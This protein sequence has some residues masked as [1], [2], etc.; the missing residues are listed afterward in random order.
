MA[1]HRTPKS[2]FWGRRTVRFVALLAA[3]LAVFGTVAGVAIA[4]WTSTGSA[5]ASATTGTLNPPTA[6]TGVQTAGTGSVTVSW[7][8]PTGGTT[9]SGYYVTRKDSANN[10]VAAC[11]T[12]AGSTTSST[13]CSDTSV[14]LGSYTYTVVA[15]F[16]SWTA[17]S[18]ASATVTVAKAA[19]SITFTSSAP[20]NAVVNGPVYTVTATGGGS[21]NAV[22]FSSATTG[23]CTVSGA[24]VSFAHAGTCT[25]NADQAGS[26]YYSPA[27]TAQQTFAVGKASQVISF[28]SSAPTNAVVAGAT[29]TVT[30]LGGASGNPV[31]FSIDGVSTSVCSIS[32]STVSYQHVGSCVVDANQA[33]NA[34]YLAAPQVQQSIAVGKGSQAVNFTSTAPS[35]AQVGGSY[36]PTATSTAGLA[37]AITLDASS[38]GCSLSSGTVS[39]TGVGTCKIDANQPGNADYLAAAQVQQSFA[40]TKQNQTISF[41]S[42]APATAKVGGATYTAVATATSGLTVSFGT[43]TP[44]VCTSSGTNGATISFL[45]VGTCTVTA[46]QAGNGTYNAA[47]Q[48]T[49]SFTVAKGD[50]TISFTSTASASAKNGGAT[51]TATATATSGL[52]VIFGTSTP[53]VCTSSGANG[54]TITFVAAGN[55]TVTANQAG[56]TTYNAAPQ[57]TQ[58]F[59]VAKGD[60]T[61]TFT[62]TAPASTTVG[63]PTYTPTATSNSGLAVAITLDATSSGCTLSSGVVSFTAVGT[64]KIDANQSGDTNW[65]A[66]TQQ[67]QSITVGKGSQTISFTST[68][69]A[70]ATVGGATYTA[71]A[72]ATSGLTVSF[73]SATTSVC[74]SGG[75]NGAVFTFVAAGTCTVNANQAGNTNYNAAPQVQQSF[76]VVSVTITTVSPSILAHNGAVTNVTVSGTGFQSGIAV[77]LSDTTFVVQSVT[78][79]N[80]TQITVAIKNNYTNNGGHPSSL[81]VTNPDAT[82]ATKSNAI[83]N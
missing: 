52:T 36:T 69:P 37:V 12:S 10:V 61:I 70:N 39:F 82:T 81:T 11:G 22:T 73:T 43:S 15:V 60:Q 79:V 25:I 30:A 18:A 44:S 32:G 57:V 19:Q 55:C 45:A 34:D 42:T 50:Q 49:Q 27:T 17:T 23:V 74:T 83:T 75:T 48:V 62:S 64:C 78:F 31:V 40:I 6:V 20:A 66:A 4:Y 59:T 5:T 58:S 9:P 38:S 13:S 41:S 24:T 77:S 33:G 53:A 54:A 1:A 80:S 72:T 16:R 8:A 35:S 47:P 63:G 26:T 3:A 71:S 65:N 14:P 76:T 56:N 29:Y 67:Q 21:G 28:T 51:Y 7:T 46:D 2:S 68:A